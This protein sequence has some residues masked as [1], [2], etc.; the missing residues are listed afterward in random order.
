MKALLFILFFILSGCNIDD[1]VLCSS[2][3]AE[4][5]DL[6]IDATDSNSWIYYRF[7]IPVP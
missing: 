7:N 5:N 6:E 2:E 3:T 1:I 4:G